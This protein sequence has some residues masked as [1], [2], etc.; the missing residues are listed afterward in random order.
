MKSIIKV[1]SE[2]RNS[3]GNKPEISLFLSMTAVGSA[4][5]DRTG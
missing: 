4:D 5:N 3:V 1:E 2:P